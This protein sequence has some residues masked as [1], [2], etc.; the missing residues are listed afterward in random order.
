MAGLSA[1]SRPPLLRHKAQKPTGMRFVPQGEQIMGG[2]GEPPAGFL[3]GQ[4]SV[5]EWIAYWALARIFQNPKGDDVRSGP[6][7]GGWPD[8]S[9]QVKF[10][11]NTT[12]G[13]TAVDFVINQGATTI[14]IRIQTERY[15]IFTS[16]RIQAYDSLQRFNLEKGMEIVDI[17]DN[18]LLGDPSGQKAIIAM[19]RAIG[20]LENINPVVARTAI[21]GSRMSKML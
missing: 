20:R 8:W 15:H 18:E 2:Y 10:S 9:Y 1:P 17:Y 12:S 19:K 4:N 7:I 11:A 5:T 21:R 14:G 3:N 13:R 16:S 6:F